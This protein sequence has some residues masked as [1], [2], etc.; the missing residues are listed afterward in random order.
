LWAQA[1]GQS[2]YDAAIDLCQRW[3][4]PLPTLGPPGPR[5]NRE[6]EPVAPDIETCTMPPT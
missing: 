5:R 2:R 4:I 6:G 1:T 3:H